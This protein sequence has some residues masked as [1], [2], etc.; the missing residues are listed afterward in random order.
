MKA[1]LIFVFAIPACAQWWNTAGNTPV[2]A[3]GFG[4][5]SWSNDV[6]VSDTSLSAG[7]SGV[8]VLMKWFNA[9]MY[10]DGAIQQVRLS[11]N[12]DAGGTW[13]L[14][15]YS[16]DWA[17][18]Y[19]YVSQSSTFTVPGTGTRTVSTTMAS[20]PVT[21]V[22]G[23]FVPHGSAINAKTTGVGSAPWQSGN[24]TTFSAGGTSA[25]TLLDLI[26]L[27]DPPALVCA[28]DSICAGHDGY[29]PPWEGYFAGYNVAS[30]TA[31]QVKQVISPSAFLYQSYGVG[32]QTCDY[33]VNIMSSV[34]LVLTKAF[35]LQCGIN[36]LVSGIGWTTGGSHGGTKG[37]LD[38][39]LAAM[40][41]GSHLFLNQIDP[42][43]NA[44]SASIDALNVNYAT[45]ATTNG[46]TL[47]LSHD[48]MGSPTG[49]NTPNPAYYSGSI[50]PNV[51]GYGVKGGIV[52]TALSNYY[53]PATGSAAGGGSSFGG[54]SAR[55]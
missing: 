47:V 46:A 25:S 53:A 16:T 15:C 14:K 21:S 2:Y 23:I 37:A 43:T 8:T 13:Q 48:A 49:S 55:R 45:W 34:N 24:V 40:P 7:S 12:A 36:D 26:V 50:H 1:L 22:L 20:C 27:G 18:A 9:T 31:Y 17:G 41:V 10:Q 39:I 35:F 32:S 30:Q 54:G 5:T 29:D 33:V 3:G 11:V 28:G 51:T 38:A 6:A 4:Q 19:T 44:S 42:T 52:A